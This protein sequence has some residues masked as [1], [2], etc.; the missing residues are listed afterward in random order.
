M[1]NQAE[2]IDLINDAEAKEDLETVA[3]II[4]YKF[5]GNKGLERT[6]SDMIELVNSVEAKEEETPVP[7]KVATPEAIQ[8]AQPVATNKPRTIRNTKTGVLFTW[9][10]SLAKMPEM[11]ED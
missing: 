10:E 9:T 6:K 4:G 8:E 7:N 2:L 3:E 1:S 5:H 11:R